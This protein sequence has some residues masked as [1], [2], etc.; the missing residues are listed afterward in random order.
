[1]CMDVFWTALENNGVGCFW[2]HHFVEAVCYADDV[3]LLAPSPSA[4]KS[5]RAGLHFP[6][7]SFLE[8]TLSLSKLA[9]NLGL[10]L[11]YNLSDEEDISSVC[12]DT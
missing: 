7:F 8:Q 6:R 11:T 12:K 3:A 9:N 5:R 2:K 10:N 1:M 4:L